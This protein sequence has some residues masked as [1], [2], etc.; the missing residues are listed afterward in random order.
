[1]NSI[2]KGDSFENEVYNHLKKELEDDRLHVAGQRSIIFSK[3]GYYSRDRER[4]IITDIS[5]ETFLPDATD[6][7]LLTVVECKD[8][9]G[10]IPVDDIEEFYSKVA[11]IS[12]ANIKAIFAT[13]SAFQKSALTFAKSKK[14]GVIRYLPSDQM[15]WLTHSVT[16]GN[17]NKKLYRSEFN[18]A[19]INQ[20]HISYERDFFACDDTSIYGS[21]FSILS[22]FIN[23]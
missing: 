16:I 4:N 20:T 13:K 10:T 9:D 18:S 14:I 6:Y 3:K 7:S 5:I 19:F 22:R 12:G 21:L 15:K 17:I 11:Q 23:I 8:Y 2:K 1:M